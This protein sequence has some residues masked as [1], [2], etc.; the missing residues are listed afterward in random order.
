VTEHAVAV[1]TGG[2]GSTTV[3]EGEQVRY[4]GDTIEPVVTSDS[5]IVEAWRRDR[6]IFQ[7]AP[8]G[9]V[10]AD[11]ERYRGGRIVIT[12]DRLRKLPVTAVFD[13]RQADA[14]IGTIANSLPVRIHRLTDYLV[15]LSP[16]S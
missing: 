14:A 10:V 15:L 11:L 8:L 12:D 16:R 7:N 2:G 5:R 1:S 4:T 13:A 3:H 6:L 9:E